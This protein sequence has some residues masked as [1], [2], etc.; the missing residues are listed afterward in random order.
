MEQRRAKEEI[1]RRHKMLLVAHITPLRLVTPDTA[2][3]PTE[4]KTK[5]VSHLVPVSATQS[6]QEVKKASGQ[7]QKT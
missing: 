5:P 6:M 3:S 2:T 1:K 4:N 7:R